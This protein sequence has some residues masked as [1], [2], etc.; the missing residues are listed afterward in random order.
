MAGQIQSL[1]VNKEK[2]LKAC[3]VWFLK[4]TDLADY[5]VK[6]KSPLETPTT[7]VQG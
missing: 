5:L 6:N 1:T 3:K 7:L 2:M 4:A